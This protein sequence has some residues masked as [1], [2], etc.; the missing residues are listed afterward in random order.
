VHRTVDVE[1]HVVAIGKLPGPNER[2]GIQDDRER[3]G[4]RRRRLS[5]G[6]GRNG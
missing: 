3:L 2:A 1:P 5:G 6:R 4:C